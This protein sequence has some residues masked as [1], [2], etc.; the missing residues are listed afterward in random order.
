MMIALG[1][2]NPPWAAGRGLGAQRDV[3]IARRMLRG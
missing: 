3:E 1:M 2:A